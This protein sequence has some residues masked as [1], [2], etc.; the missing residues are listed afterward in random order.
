MSALSHA[1]IHFNAQGTPVATDF[2]DI[3][4]SNDGGLAETDYVF[5]Q[6]NG[7]PE[8][9]QSH[10]R[11][12]FHVLETGFGTGAN[13][14]LC[15]QRFREY[16]R[17]YPDAQCQRLYF[18]S[19]E[20]YPL[21]RA[22][23]TQALSV[24]TELAPLCQQLLAAY[25]PAT[26][27]CHRLLLDGGQ[28][29][30]DLWLGDVNV[31]LP[32]VPE[33][34]RVDAIFL[35][36][37]APA[38]NPDMWQPGLFQQLFRLS[39]PGTRLATFTCAGVVKRGLSE[40]GFQLT[41]VKGFGKKREMLIAWHPQPAESLSPD[42]QHSDPV[43]DPVTI[44]GGGL[45]ALTTAYALLRRGIAVNLLCADAEVAQGASHNRQGALYPNLPVKLTPQGLFHCQAFWQAR[46]FY[47]HCQQLGLDFPLDYCGVLHLA[48][49]EQLA[50]RQQ[51]MA[52][53]AVWPQ[54]LLQ[55]VDAAAAT[56]LAGVTLQQ[57]GIFLPLAGWLAPQA[58][59]QALWRYLSTQPG[60]SSQFNC[61]VEQLAAHSDGWRLHTTTT[62]L[63]AQQL[64]VAN[65]ADLTR[66][67]PFAA[68]PVNR[69]RGQVSHVEAP[70]L[71]PLR[72]VICHKGY[73]TPAWQGL[74]CIGA[75][76]DRTAETAELMDADD[77]QNIA[78]LRQQLQQPDWSVKLAV[79]SAKAAFRATVPDH[80]P[81]C[82]RYHPENTGEPA[83]LW[84]NVGLGARG[85][86]FAP[87]QAEILAAQISGEP[88]PTGQTGLQLLSPARFTKK[89]AT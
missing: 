89:T 57:G 23:L 65:G 50:E 52:A 26:A 58:F 56:K 55:F 39:Y 76:F 36:G 3:Y 67:A 40:A 81:L 32:T 84:L 31:L 77:T 44:I 60:F 83:P 24:H 62:T 74:H 19:F 2:D 82:G 47:Q 79:H 11:P 7:L 72:T 61:R 22:D 78:E 42:R 51:K 70:D 41:K 54:E 80:L 48:S 37:F 12:W 10:T 69:V 87:L 68:L 28:V 35:D 46:Q 15:W 53:A 9:W 8:R 13:F 20:K 71:A 1:R 73:L 88:I 21:S 86:L 33:Q 63:T 17:Q 4:F 18:S 38:K 5:L 25:P 14:L 16:R 59:C 29:M 30:L 34:N 64:L 75:T 66:L 6:Q 49:T 43:S 45:A 85:L 27:G